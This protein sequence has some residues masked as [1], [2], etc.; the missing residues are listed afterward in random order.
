M[1]SNSA[2]PPVEDSAAKARIFISYSRKDMAF[3][4]RLDNALKRRGFAPLIDRSEIYA[5]EDW[6]RRI[7][8]LIVK[9]DTI[10]FVLSPNAIASEVCAK[11]VNFAASLNKRFAPIEPGP[12]CA[13][14]QDKHGRFP[15]LDRR[16]DPPVR[17]SAPDWDDGQ[18]GGRGAGLHGTAPIRRRSLR[19]PA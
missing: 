16:G 2:K 18:D 17:S 10:V 7:E 5:F 13:L 19:P 8:A 3:A 11:E 14:S 15:H 1:S 6:W 4:D 12:R 9:A